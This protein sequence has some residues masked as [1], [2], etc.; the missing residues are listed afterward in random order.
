[1]VRGQIGLKRQKT[2]AFPTRQDTV[3]H[4]L[5]A[6]DNK[7]TVAMKKTQGVHEQITKLEHEILAQFH[8]LRPKVSLK[9]INATSIKHS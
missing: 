9:S 3:L 4:R 1:M 8:H 6:C 5:A 7:Q 2:H